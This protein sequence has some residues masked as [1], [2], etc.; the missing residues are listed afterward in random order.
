M[1]EHKTNIDTRNQSIGPFVKPQDL[2]T[3]ASKPLNCD[4]GLREL[5]CNKIDVNYEWVVINVITM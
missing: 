5:Q 2:R 4:G 1:P 3:G